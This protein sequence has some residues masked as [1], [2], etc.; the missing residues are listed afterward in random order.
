V[1]VGEF[2]HY[3]WQDTF[4]DMTGRKVSFPEI[5][6]L[7]GVVKVKLELFGYLVV[8]KCTSKIISKKEGE[9]TLVVSG[10]TDR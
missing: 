6:I 3:I 4:V 1:Y 5:R 10:C 9:L 2:P 7:I 8:C